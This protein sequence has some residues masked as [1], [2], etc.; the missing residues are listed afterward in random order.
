VISLAQA[1]RGRG[2]LLLLLLAAWGPAAVARGATVRAVRIESEG[3]IAVDADAVQAFI[4]VRP[5]AEYDPL[6]VGRDVRALEATGQY[7]HIR[8]RAVA[9]DDGVVVVYHVRARPRI[10]RI[11]I[12]GADA[13]GNRRVLELMEI[14][15]GDPANEGKLAAGVQRVREE[16]RK[17]RYPYARVEWTVEPPDEIGRSVVRIR[18][19]EG[20][21]ARVS[22]IC[23]EGNRA[24]SDDELASVLRQP[25]YVW[26]NPWH[27][28]VGT[29]RL[30]EEDVEADRYAIRRAY[31]DRGYLD[32]RVEP[33]EISF[34]N[35]RRL[36]VTYRIEEGEPYRIASVALRGVT[37]FPE[38]EL[39][40][41]ISLAAGAPA[42]V[43]AMEAAAQAIGDYYGNRGYARTYARPITRADP[44]KRTVDVILDV[45]EGPL[46]R[47]RDI[48]VRGNAITKDRVIRRELAVAPGETFN[49]ERVRVSER[50]L[51]NL[52]YFSNVQ[53]LLEPTPDPAETDLVFE[54]EEQ[55]MGQAMLSM[56]FSSIDEISGALEIS[57]G[58][59]DIRDWPPL[60]GGQKVRARAIIGTKRS[61]IELSFTEPWL[62]GRRL[63]LGLDLFRSEKRYLSSD[64]D[65][66][67]TGGAVSL[68]RP[69]G[70]FSRLRTAYSLEEIS[71]YDVDRSAS[72]RI[73]E[74]EGT[75]LKSALSL[76]LS[77][78]TRDRI[79]VPTRGFRAEATASVAGG[80][81]GGETDIYSI[82]GSFVQ[83][84]PLWRDHVLSWRARAGVVDTHGD[85]DRVPIF[86]RYFLG[87]ASTI[88]GFDYRDVAPR[89]DQGEPIGGRSLAF[90]SAE[91]SIP[92]RGPFRA[93]VF[94]DVGLVDAD[95]Y[96]FSADPNASW[97]I[98]LRVDLRMLPLRL[99]YSWPVLTDDYND[100]A[101]GR[102]SFLLGYGF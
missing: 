71:I 41:A 25:R 16:Y 64:Y 92:I 4:G 79:F 54:V 37:L 42:S 91:Y 102:F 68:T 31:L 38:E 49:R 39:L 73:R 53:T 34:I 87:G 44:E 21:R 2:V 100:G 89:D 19:S 88:R 51:L 96:S 35:A 18:V 9:E 83:Y 66:R 50:R 65:Q 76:T 86:D 40:R 61:D 5:G 12:T 97:G 94:Y 7:E 24:L 36:R 23:F 10:G 62:F 90:A 74:E 33:P 43:G 52:G 6:Q 28:I 101:S 3:P 15:L 69:V 84:F 58:N 56:G 95:A 20:P 45:R 55:S 14:A 26:Y 72:D 48:R 46:T 78:D 81:L 60:G 1:R 57:H 27:W 13:L 82:E 98:G 30:Q 85:G 99:D 29:G 75:R 32:V 17:Y 8:V 63:A 80:P 47:L 70:R 93:A 59:F 77:Q 11:E 67:N 22:E